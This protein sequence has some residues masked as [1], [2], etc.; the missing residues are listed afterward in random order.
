MANADTVSEQLAIAG[1][2]AIELL[3]SDLPL[4]M[5]MTLEDA[6]DLTMALGPAGEVLRLWG[7]RAEEI[8]PTIAAEIRAALEQFE[9]ADGVLAPVLDLGDLGACA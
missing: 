5:G 1:F 9:T 3:R 6:V 7:D 8:R 4:R 2:E